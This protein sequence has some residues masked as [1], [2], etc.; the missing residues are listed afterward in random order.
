MALRL[1]APAPVTPT[2]KLPDAATA[3]AP[4]IVDDSIVPVEAD[5]TVRS[6][7]VSVTVAS[8]I[9]AFVK[10]RDVGVPISFVATEMPAAVD[11]FPPTWAA[12][13]PATAKILAESSASTLSDCAV[14]SALSRTAA[15]LRR[16]TRFVANDPAPAKENP[17]PAMPP[18][19]PTERAPLTPT[20][21]ALSVPPVTV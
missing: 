9:I 15:V 7:P 12:S 10:P 13:A 8:S 3:P 2:P 14:T 18:P 19:E 5:L 11:T 21:Q 1:T 4:A 16:V 6:P 20:A 17:L